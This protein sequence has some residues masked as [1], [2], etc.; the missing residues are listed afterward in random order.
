MD[1]LPSI[2]AI[3]QR[4]RDRHLYGREPLFE[5]FRDELLADRRAVLQLA[6]KRLEAAWADAGPIRKLLLEL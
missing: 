2:D 4:I 3:R 5:V 6:A 1:E